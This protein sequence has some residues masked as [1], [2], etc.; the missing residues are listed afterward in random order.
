MLLLRD[1]SPQMGGVILWC[2]AQGVHCV[3]VSEFELACIK[4]EKIRFKNTTQKVCAVVIR[5]C[6]IN[7]Q[8]GLVEGWSVTKRERIVHFRQ[9]QTPSHSVQNQHNYAYTHSK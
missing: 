2:C 9:T 6:G 4:S 1:F 8:A 5:D 3:I 7:M